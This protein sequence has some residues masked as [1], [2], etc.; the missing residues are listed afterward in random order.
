MAYR[1]RTT[2]RSRS[3]GRRGSTSRRAS[4][5]RRYTG[6]RSSSRVSGRRSSARTVRIELVQAPINPVARPAVPASMVGMMPAAS[7]KKATF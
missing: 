1:R 2:T 5:S 7:P 3:Y 6:R 4:G